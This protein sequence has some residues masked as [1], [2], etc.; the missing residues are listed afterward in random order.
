M[1][2]QGDEVPKLE[3]YHAMLVSLRVFLQTVREHEWDK[4]TSYSRIQLPFKVQ[5]T[6]EPWTLKWD[7]RASVVLFVTLEAPAKRYSNYSR[8]INVKKVKLSSSTGMEISSVPSEFLI[9][10]CQFVL[11]VFNQS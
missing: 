6:C 11:T 2:L 9:S 5:N 7:D 8:Q 1:N 4:V 10:F 3:P